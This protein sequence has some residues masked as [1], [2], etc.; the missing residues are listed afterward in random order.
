MIRDWK[1]KISARRRYVW[2]LPRVWVMGRRRV[3]APRLVGGSYDPVGRAETLAYSLGLPEA[4]P[5][6]FDWLAELLG[7]RSPGRGDN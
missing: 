1:P 2:G 7:E 6:P 4:E 5:D 3:S